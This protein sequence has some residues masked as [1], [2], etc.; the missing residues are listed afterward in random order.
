MNVR[1]LARLL[2][3]LGLAA[4]VALG[5][6]GAAAA[7][8]PSGADDRGV[9]DEGG[10]PRQDPPADDVETDDDEADDPET[11]EP[12]PRVENP[13]PIPVDLDSDAIGGDTPGD[14]SSGGG[15]TPT[16]D[17]VDPHASAPTANLRK[18]ANALVVTQRT[19]SIWFE[20]DAPAGL[21]VGP[22]EISVGW[23]GQRFTGY[24]DDTRATA[25]RFAFPPLTGAA[26]QEYISVSLLE[27]VPGGPYAYSIVKPV[28]VVPL[29]DITVSRLHVDVEGSCDLIGSADPTVFW[30]DP[31]GVQHQDFPHS[32][33]TGNRSEFGSVAAF[34][35]T[36]DNATVSRGLTRPT[37][38]WVDED[39]GGFG[40]VG[41]NALPRGSALLP[42]AASYPGVDSTP[43]VD[44]VSQRLPDAGGDDCS[45]LM[46]Y[47]ISYRLELGLTAS[48]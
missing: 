32:Y 29:Y 44:E 20:V 31:E 16:A 4:V 19:N 9:V 1:S 45:A 47:T 2:A 33:D 10:Q 35:G 3:A 46:Y 21:G 37:L 36:W 30:V 18:L 6:V 39:P 43:I 5:T 11:E 24:Y 27:R 28:T 8:P 7:M 38:E 13:G 17:Q 22:I 26:R 34:A 40:T 42:F 12:D 48:G 23:G 15:G 41:E 25:Y 14:G